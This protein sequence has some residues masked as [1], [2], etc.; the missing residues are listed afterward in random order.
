MEHVVPRS[1]SGGLL[2]VACT[3]VAPTRVAVTIA[4]GQVFA[5]PPAGTGVYALTQSRDPANTGHD[6]VDPVIHLLPGL[7]QA[8]ASYTLTVFGYQIVPHASGPVWQP[9]PLWQGTVAATRAAASPFSDGAFA[10][11]DYEAATITAAAGGDAA[12]ARVTSYGGSVGAASVRV[13][14]RA[15]PFLVFVADNPAAFVLAG[16]H[17]G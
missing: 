12:D 5:T 4:T 13:N 6:G 1:N 3:T 15:C 14:T 17:S 2:R 16:R 9:I 7:A 10:D 11:G 8:T